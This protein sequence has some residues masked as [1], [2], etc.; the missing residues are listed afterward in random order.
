MQPKGRGIRFYWF[1]NQHEVKKKKGMGKWHIISLDRLASFE[2]FLQALT[3][4]W[5]YTYSET[6]EIRTPLALDK[7]FPYFRGV[8]I[9]QWE[10]LLEK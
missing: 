9:S 3:H 4:Q 6:R 8:L 1:W 5:P 10:L 7:R 2:R